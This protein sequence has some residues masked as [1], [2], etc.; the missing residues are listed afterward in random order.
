MYKSLTGVLGVL[1]P[2]VFVSAV[3]WNGTAFVRVQQSRTAVIRLT[4]HMTVPVVAGSFLRPQR[5]VL[6]EPAAPWLVTWAWTLQQLRL[7]TFTFV[8]NSAFSPIHPRDLLCAIY[9]LCQDSIAAYFSQIRGGIGQLYCS[10]YICPRRPASLFGAD[11]CIFFKYVCRQ[12]A[13]DSL[14][15]CCN[16]QSFSFRTGLNVC[17]L[18]IQVKR[19]RW[20]TLCANMGCCH[21]LQ[22]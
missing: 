7:L 10:Y 3:A 13:D 12:Q 17:R 19:R 20:T 14:L 16:I 1:L 9:F 6:T 21:I 8:T 5:F 11:N 2:G 22:H 15:S 18:D 4:S